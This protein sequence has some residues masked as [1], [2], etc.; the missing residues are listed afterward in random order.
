MHMWGLF[1]KEFQSEQDADSLICGAQIYFD[2]GWVVCANVDVNRALKLR[3][4][5]DS[6]IV[7][8]VVSKILHLSSQVW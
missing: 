3:I 2:N 5:S 4:L 8:Q 1:L 7:L 6:S